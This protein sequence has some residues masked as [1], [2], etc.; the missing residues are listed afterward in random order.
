[1][2]FIANCA[3]K[4][5]KI[6][7]EEDTLEEAAPQYEEYVDSFP[8]EIIA[9]VEKEREAKKAKNKQ[10]KPKSSKTDNKSDKSK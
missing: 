8:P 7:K 6:G 2:I 5:T 3:I 9:Q 1:M 4:I 10:D